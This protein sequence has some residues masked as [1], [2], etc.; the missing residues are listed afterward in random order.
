MRALLPLSAD[1]VTFGHLALIRE[2]RARFDEMVVALLD[3]DM[4]TGRYLFSTHERVQLLSNAVTRLGRDNV[5]V[6]VA[7]GILLA[8]VFLREGCDVIVRGMR[9]E[10]EG[11]T[12]REQS[13]LHELVLSGIGKRF[14]Y[15]PTTDA[16][17]DVSSTSVKAFVSHGIDV[18]RFV[19]LQT[20]QALEERILGQY[21][22]GVTGPIASGKSFVGARLATRL[23]TLGVPCAHVSYDAILR[24]LYAERTPGADR[25]RDEIVARLG[26][27]VRGADGLID[28]TAM[29]AKLFHPDC[30]METRRAIEG[31]TAPHVFRLER[32]RLAGFRGIVLI[33]CAT[34]VEMG[35]AGRV[36]NHVV[37]VDSPERPSM[38]AERGIDPAR[39][40]EVARHQSTSDELVSTLEA[41][42]TSD[43]NGSVTRYVNRR[44]TA[45][46][47]SDGDILV[48]ANAILDLFPSI[49]R[50]VT[51]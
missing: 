50:E 4:K 15:I 34:L 40:S 42:V 45:I 26:A 20:K 22:V 39:T 35:L 36:N 9:S 2:A 1:P 7:P 38:L 23:P 27:E 14:Q 28:R 48:L 6:I 31:L 32:E 19:P 44:R 24:D 18:S 21:T 17:R 30:P 3:N 8:D 25:L 33:E 46:G 37:V 51:P 49:P 16:L 10:A 11:E 41:R 13:R 29:S 43:G 47:A 12:E 5:R